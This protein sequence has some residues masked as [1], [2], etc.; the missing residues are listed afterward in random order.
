MERNKTALEARNQGKNIAIIAY[1]TIIGL[2]IAYVKN[3]KNETSLGSFHIRQSLGITVTALI[4]SLLRF[5]P[6]VG[7]TLAGVVG[8]IILVA[9]I[10]GIISAINAEEKE[11]PF[12]GSLY[13]KWFSA[14]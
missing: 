6:G 7:N 14:I 3:S 11:L 5:V 2:A 9:L 10:L 4:S 13:Q 12:V 1:L 8:L